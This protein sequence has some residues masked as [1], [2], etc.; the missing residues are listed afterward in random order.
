ME[1]SLQ[2][3]SF[4]NNLF[5]GLME[6]GSVKAQVGFRPRSDLR[7]FFKR[8]EKRLGAVWIATAIFLNET[9]INS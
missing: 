4:L 6:Q 9:D 8:R 3:S 7:G 2:V 5:F 1:G